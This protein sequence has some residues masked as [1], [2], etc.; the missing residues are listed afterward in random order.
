MRN[1]P[2]ATPDERSD[3]DIVVYDGQCGMCRNQMQKL[4]WWDW[5]ERLSYVSLHAPEVRDRW[6][7]LSKDRLLEEMAVVTHQ[8]TIHWG[9]TAIRYLTRRLPSLWWLMPLLHIPG[10]MVLWR[11]LYRWVAR[12]RYWFGGKLEDCDTGSCRVH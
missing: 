10:S 12:N 8:G 7:Q 9:P 2:L 3:A 5:G 1:S 4:R 6:P 11:P